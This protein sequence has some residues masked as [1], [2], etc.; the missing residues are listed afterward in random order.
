[1]FIRYN[2]LVNLGIVNN[3][4][5]LA[6]MITSGSFPKPVKIHGHGQRR[7]NAW[8]LDEVD[9]WVERCMER[10]SY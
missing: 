9:E 3:R 1:M 8:L 2:D 6:R 4:M 10:R 5:T 7:M